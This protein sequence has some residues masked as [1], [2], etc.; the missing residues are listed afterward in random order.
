M[1]CSILL[2]S[3]LSPPS[4]GKPDDFLK[5]ALRMSAITESV[6]NRRVTEEELGSSASADLAAWLFFQLAADHVFLPILVATFVFSHSVIRHSTVINICCTW[7]LSGIISSLLLYSGEASGPEPSQG[8]CTVQA[9]LMSGALPMTSV[10][11][12]ALAYRTWRSCTPG[13]SQLR[14]KTSWTTR[15]MFILAPYITLGVFCAIAANLGVQYPSHVDR[16]TRFFYCAVNLE[17]FAIAIDVFSAV[18]C[19]I[20]AGLFV[21]LA[22]LQ[23]R[24]REIR[25]VRQHSAKADTALRIRVGLLTLYM[26]TATLANLGSLGD[27]GTAFP[28]IFTA[29]VG[30]AVFVIFA[31]QFDVLRAWWSW[32]PCQSPL[33]RPRHARNISPSDARTPYP[34]F[35]LDLLNKRTD[36]DVSDK[37]RLEALHTYYAARVRG[38]GVKVE[39][40]DRPQD[41]FIRDGH[42][43]RR[44][45]VESGLAGSKRGRS[46]A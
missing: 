24:S 27:P 6:H 12:L 40:I 20:A 3:A 25:P 31:S 38:E 23:L 30:M 13:T 18:V 14:E 39:I 11:T 19:I 44:A 37:A 22:M 8:L 36:S 33:A 43:L 45:S 2:S 17:A 46:W 4:V 32:R 34:S 26:L 15:I 10:A 16:G 21:H 41:A 9:A 1:A 28:D 5:P 35:D 29:S 7:I 42:E